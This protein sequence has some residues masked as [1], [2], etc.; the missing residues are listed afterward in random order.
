MTGGEQDP[1][2]GVA[3]GSA[4][5]Y[6]L[7]F[8]PESRRDALAAVFALGRELDRISIRRGEPSVIQTKLRW[9]DE[10]IRR[11]VKREARHPMTR[12][13]VSEPS[14]AGIESLL[15][16][17]VA[18]TASLA[19]S[20]AAADDNKTIEMDCRRGAALL[21]TVAVMLT[22]G[23]DADQV[24]IPARNIGAAGRLIDLLRSEPALQSSRHLLLPEATAGLA[25]GLAG[26]P[27]ERHAEL[28]PILVYGEIQR[29]RLGG[30]DMPQEPRSRLTRA[31][32]TLRDLGT[33]WRTARRAVREQAPSQHRETK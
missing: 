17:M 23:R 6:A 9:W 28:A 22:N 26:V 21:G 3:E 2:P 8:T 14:L 27:R 32:D 15:L 19:Q 25:E 13:L 12:A 4:A 33:A 5:Y 24:L 20:V 1:V 11:L 31:F 10:E 30:P 7:L 29:R 18:C 16:E